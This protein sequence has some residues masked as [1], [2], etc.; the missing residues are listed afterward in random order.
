MFCFI[1]WFHMRTVHSY[2][3]LSILYSKDIMRRIQDTKC[4]RFFFFL[5]FWSMKMIQRFYFTG[6]DFGRG[7]MTSAVVRYIS[8]HRLQRTR[9]GS[10]FV[11]SASGCDKTERVHCVESRLASFQAVHRMFFFHL[12]HSK[13]CTQSQTKFII[14]IAKHSKLINNFRWNFKIQI[15][16]PTSPIW[17]CPPFDWRKMIGCDLNWIHW[18]RTARKWLST[19]YAKRLKS[20]KKQSKIWEIYFKVITINSNILESIKY[21][22]ASELMQMRL[23]SAIM[24]YNWRVLISLVKECNDYIFSA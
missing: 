4:N 5:S 20:R 2:G 10:D 1:W 17:I 11:F 9:R 19:N 23:S 6:T 16:C 24:R 15:C 14:L 21:N 3:H 7:R 22:S 13:S 18:H 8:L 12:H